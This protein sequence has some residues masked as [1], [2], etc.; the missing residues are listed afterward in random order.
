MHAETLS[1]LMNHYIV[2]YSRERKN[3]SIKLNLHI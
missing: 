1:D 3:I 2:F